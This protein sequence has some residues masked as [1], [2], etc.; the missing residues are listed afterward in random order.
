MYNVRDRSVERNG[1]RGLRDMVNALVRQNRPCT[2]VFN[3][4]DFGRDPLNNGWSH[5]INR[6]TMHMATWYRK[7]WVCDNFS[8]RNVVNIRDLNG[9]FLTE[10]HDLVH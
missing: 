9:I 1:E 10:I 6:Y 4:F 7:K 8:R 3:S 2:V 5:R